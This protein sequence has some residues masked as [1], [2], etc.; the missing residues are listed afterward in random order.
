MP[1]IGHL[2]YG[3]CIAQGLFTN[4]AKWS[5]V[6]Y[7]P[8]MTTVQSDLWSAAGTL[9]FPVA[10]TQIE[11]LS[12][13]NTN[14]IGNSIFN[15]T[16]SGGS[17]T[18]L[19]D[20]SKNFLGGTPV[21]IGD[22]VIL[23]KGTN[24]EWGYVTGVATTT[25][26][27]AGGFSKGGSG[28]ARVYQ[29][30]DQSATTGAQVAYISGLDNAFAAL[31]E[32]IVFNGSTAV[33]SALS[34]WYR[35]NSFRVVAAGST[36]ACVGACTLRKAAA[37]AVYSFITAAYTR[38]RNSGYTV[39]TGKTLWVSSFSV[40][41]SITGNANKEYARIFTR[42]QQYSSESGIMFRTPGIWYPYTETLSSTGTIDKELAEPTKILSGVDLKI[43]GI[44]SA[45]GVASGVYRG[46]LTTP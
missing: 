12:G 38:A 15:G 8:T 7:T 44:A 24:P 2:S 39:P 6:G 22:C 25:L 19:T 11:I 16:S 13:D 42:A 37:G 23:D 10:A 26:T 43:S 3:E 27:I 18:T 4:I 29:V 36:G 30:I 45:A 34:T 31:S 33:A 46:Y 5:K 1:Y 9:N 21:A 28:S 35:I 40:G 17:T 20:A 41:Y 32:L 14:D